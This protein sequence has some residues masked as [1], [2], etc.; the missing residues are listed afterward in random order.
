L[1]TPA[2]VKLIETLAARLAPGGGEPPVLLSA[3]A[4]ASTVIEDELARRG[5][6]FVSD[7]VDLVDATVARPYVRG[8][9]RCSVEAM[10]PLPAAAYDLAFSNYLLEHVRDI[11][12][13]ASEIHRVLKP[14]GCFVASVPN[15]TAPEFLLA[16]WT[17]LW[18]HRV[19]LRR[20]VGEKH[21]SFRSIPHLRAIFERAGFR[22]QAVWHYA[23]TEDYL[24]RVPGLRAVARAYDRALMKAGW[25]RVLGNVCLVFEK[26]SGA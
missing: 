26:P 18:F 6:R 9:Y 20:P 2:E 19:L 1:Q 22:V 7:R 8:V 15:P 21:Y 13:A 12:A 5:C 11:E 23:S 14:G 24:Q 16:R 17:P 4:G 25:E 10:T 3:G